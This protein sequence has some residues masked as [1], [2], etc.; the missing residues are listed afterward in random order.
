[1]W[2]VFKIKAQLPSQKKDLHNNMQRLLQ[3]IALAAFSAVWDVCAL[4]LTPWTDKGVFRLAMFRMALMY[5][6][7]YLL[8]F[9]P[10]WLFFALL[11][12]V[13][14]FFFGQRYHNH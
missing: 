1:V 3:F 6:V 8:A 5:F 12:S 7:I 14:K 10:V 4:D 9:L 11:R 13:L 2:L